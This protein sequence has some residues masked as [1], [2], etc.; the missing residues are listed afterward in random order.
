MGDQAASK[1]KRDATRAATTSQLM[2]NIMTGGEISKKR[3][4]EL[5]EAADR[6]RGIQ[7]VE[8]TGSVKGLK[9]FKRD[10]S[11]KIM[12]DP[13]T[14][15]KLTK[16]VMKT[17]ATAADYTGKI[18]S[19]APTGGELIQD[20][21]R[22]LFGGKADDSAIR[23]VKLT[24][25]PGDKTPTNFSKFL[26]EPRKTKGIVPTLIEKGG[27]VG[28]IASSI[29]TGKDKKK[30]KPTTDQ[31]YNQGVQSFAALTRNQLGGANPKLGD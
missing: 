9:Q 16:A 24:N 29:L 14:G 23:N 4:K 11:G 2:N 15:K 3:E 28:S 26:P 10:A 30:Q 12:T 18:T 25:R 27:V 20:A 19:S 1:N 6:G 21:G 8:T 17:G 22:A 13:E 7:F 5:Q 31:I